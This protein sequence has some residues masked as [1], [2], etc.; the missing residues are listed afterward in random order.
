M[1]DS[2]L[3]RLRLTRENFDS[4]VPKEFPKKMIVI[5]LPLSEKGILLI[6]ESLSQK[7]SP[8]IGMKKHASPIAL[9]PFSFALK[10]R[11]KG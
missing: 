2:S 1:V 8:A 3:S 10:H 4:L 7:R 5:S 9:I 6:Q 11:D